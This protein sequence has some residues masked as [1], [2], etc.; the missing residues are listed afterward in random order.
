MPEART[1]RIER[2]H[3]DEL[4]VDLTH[5]ELVLSM[6]HRLGVTDPERV[7]S[8]E[9]GLAK[10]SFTL[11]QVQNGVRALERMNWDQSK[12]S[13]NEDVTRLAAERDMDR[14]SEVDQLLLGLRRLFAD[15]HDNWTPV[16]GK[17]RY[18]ERVVG[19]PHVSG[20]DQGDPR[21]PEQPIQS[22]PVRRSE[23]GQGVRVGILDTKLQAHPWLTG[24]YVAQSEALL[25]PA[26]GPPFPSSGTDGGNPG[27]REGHATFVAGLILRSAEGATVDLRPVLDETADGDSWTVA[28][29]LVKLAKADA[30]VV[31]LSL[32]TFA[33]DGQPPLVFQRAI[34]RLGSR[35]VIVAAAGNHGN[36]GPAVGDRMRPKPNSAFWPAAFTDVVAVG[37]LDPNGDD[38][39]F[40]PSVPWIDVTAPGVNV[41]S[42]YLIGRVALLRDTREFTGYARW[43]GTSFAAAIVSGA[44][45]AG[46]RPGSRSGRDAVMALLGSDS[47]D[48]AGRPFVALPPLRS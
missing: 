4:V 10:L 19:Q 1:G 46:I 39:Q 41:T 32:G 17:N 20:G 48:K 12:H 2:Y 31:N 40:S 38:A 25:Q 43:D 11:D 6:L 13:F 34:E 26:A 21:Q 14:V 47:R 24:A 9:L 16:M 37:A 22:W 23:P 30:D 3:G 35:T 27:W 45:A 36:A 44:I 42:T 15:A 29:E 28:N 5:V 18:V 33:D 7:N 8:D